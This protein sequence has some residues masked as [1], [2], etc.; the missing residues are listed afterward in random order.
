MKLTIGRHKDNDL[1]LNDNTVSGKHAEV[2][3]SENFKDFTLVDLQSANGSKVNGRKIASKKITEKDSFQ[4][5]NSKVAG[6]VLFKTLNNH[7]KQARTDFSAEFTT[8]LGIES[9][10]KSKRRNLNKNYRLLAMLPR[11]LITIGIVVVIYLIPNLGTELRYPLMIGATLVGS[12]ISTLGISE[13]KKEELLDKLKTRFQLEFVCPKCGSEFYGKEGFFWKE[14]KTC[15]NK[16][17]NATWHV[18]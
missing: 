18:N 10:Y 8:L 9:Q 4:F 14:K 7:I 12:T 13:R 5:G 17:C 1:V 3:I 16:N 6:P 15:R 11:L 2:K